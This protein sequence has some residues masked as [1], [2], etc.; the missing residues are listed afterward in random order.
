MKELRVFSL[1]MSS[2]LLTMLL[3]VAG[4]ARAESFTYDSVR[5]VSCVACGTNQLIGVVAVITVDQLG[6]L[7]ASDV[8]D[9][10]ITLNPGTTDFILSPDN[11]SFTLQSGATMTAT[12]E[13]LT[14]TMPVPGEG[15]GFT[16]S[17]GTITWNIFESP[18]Q[19]GEVA[20]VNQNGEGAFG[21]DLSNSPTETFVADAL[22][23]T[24]PLAAT[25]E[26]TTLL[27]L[28]TGLAGLLR[29]RLNFFRRWISVN[30][31]YS[32]SQL[33]YLL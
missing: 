15:F 3:W 7:A 8:M 13:S 11:S 17:D 19:P 24:E 33:S 18:A 16:S 23:G 25:P 9:W 14:I 4:T 28:G 21:F 27:L 30:I 12:P 10:S 29:T 31:L 32:G 6:T 26:P 2:T 20:Q 1:R 22:L 5:T